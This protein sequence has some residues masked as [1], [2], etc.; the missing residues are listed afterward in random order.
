MDKTVLITGAA[1]GI[2]LA[3]ST[4]LGQLGYTVIAVDLQSEPLEILEKTLSEE[5]V[6][7]FPVIADVADPHSVSIMKDN[8][9]DR[10][11][12]PDIII[13]NAGI[14]RDTLFMRMKFDDWQRVLHVNLDSAFLVTQAF[15]RGLMK[16]KWGRIIMIS[17]VVAFSGN[18]GQTNYAT[19]KA[20]LLGLTRSLAR[21]VAARNIT[22]NAIAPGFIDT[23]MTR[24]I[25]QE[26]R[27]ALKKLIPLKRYGM[28]EDVVNAVEFLI[29]KESDYITGQVLHINGG[30]FM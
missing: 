23:E 12:F 10:G 4:A 9:I 14:T 8:I 25:P 26:R 6:S 28:P 7:C 22:V 19:S 2:G 30:L 17:S 21:E 5:G 27:E 15:I 3:I 18:A 29:S 1:Q 11:L 16:K 20:G 24:R 13:N